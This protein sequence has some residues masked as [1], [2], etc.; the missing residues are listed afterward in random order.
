M[1]KLIKKPEGWYELE[2]KGAIKFCPFK[3][4]FPI[5]NNNALNVI[6]Q[7]CNSTCIYFDYTTKNV[8]LS[9]TGTS[10]MF[11]IDE[12]VEQK[13]HTNNFNII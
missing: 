3:S 6:Q 10:K 5:Q 12:V 8:E 1:N 2:N 11:D 7:T 4:Q 9:C 13:I